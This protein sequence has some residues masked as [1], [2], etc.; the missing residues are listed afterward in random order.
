MEC[1]ICMNQISSQQA[2]AKVC[3]KPALCRACAENM[4]KVNKALKCPTCRTE[5]DES[6]LDSPPPMDDNDDEFEVA[7]AASALTHKEEQKMLEAAE[8]EWQQALDAAIQESMLEKQ[9]P[10]EEK[11]EEEIKDAIAASLEAQKVRDAAEEKEDAN[12][13]KALQNSKKIKSKEDE[14]L[15]RAL[16]RSLKPSVKTEQQAPPAKRAKSE[17]KSESK[18]DFQGYKLIR[19]RTPSSA[20]NEDL[21]LSTNDGRTLNVPVDVSLKAAL[22]LSLKPSTFFRRQREQEESG[23]VC[24]GGD[25]NKPCSSNCPYRN[26][27]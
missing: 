11:M 5:L 2:V 19:T 9:N 24:C 12:L 3:C 1:S 17:T 22:E 18:A 13:V 25:P 27:V 6:V 26:R 23:D 16:K 14:D 7:L 4:L 21:R 8:L 20:Q 15:R 10:S